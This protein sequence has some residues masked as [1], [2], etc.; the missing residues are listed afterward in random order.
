MLSDFPPKPAQHDA[1]I[2]PKSSAP[3]VARR[4]GAWRAERAHRRTREA[5]E[6]R[7][8]PHHDDAERRQRHL[9]VVGVQMR[10]R[11]HQERDAE[12]D[13]LPNVAIRLRGRNSLALLNRLCSRHGVGAL[14]SEAG[15]PQTR[16]GGISQVRSLRCTPQTARRA[17]PR[18]PMSRSTPQPAFAASARSARRRQADRCMLM[19]PIDG[20]SAVASRKNAPSEVRAGAAT[21]G[22]RRLLLRREFE[23]RGRHSPC[24]AGRLGRTGVVCSVRVQCT[25]AGGLRLRPAPRRGCRGR[26]HR[27]AAAAT[28]RRRSTGGK[29]S[30]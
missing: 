26:Q 9:A 17:R 12:G 5:H 29:G 22:R 7:V 13:G 6:A 19:R 18:R 14:R 3:C 24:R 16:G 11:D 20:D 23:G 25:Y 27:V 2:W 4:G 28:L 15:R 10:R 8:R 30:E 1:R 21:D